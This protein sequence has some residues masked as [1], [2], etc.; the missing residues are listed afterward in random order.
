MLPTLR[1]EG[2]RYWESYNETKIELNM[3]RVSGVRCLL[4]GPQELGTKMSG[5]QQQEKS[6][7][8]TSIVGQTWKRLA[9]NRGKW[10]MAKK[11]KYI[12]VVE[13]RL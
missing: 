9:N 11:D 1:Y 8:K 4:N 2:Q 5:I 7:E 6:D 10:R 3:R 12:I 13:F